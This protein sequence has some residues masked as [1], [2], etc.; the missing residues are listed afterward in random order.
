MGKVKITIGDWSEDGHNQY[1]EFVY[2][3][4]KSVKDIRQAYKDSC[5]LTGLQFNH[6]ENYTG[7]EVH[8]SYGTPYHICTEYDEDTISDIAMG[9]LMEHDIE[10]GSD[11]LSVDEFAELIIDFIKL[12]L[13]DLVL[14]EA[15]F[16]KSELRDISA[17]NGWWNHELNVGFGYGLYGKIN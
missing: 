8:N 4:N 17:V 3:S 15:S 14:E 5:K 9:I 16:K 13:P 11:Y 7:T 10:V 12:S 2:E 1:D 6:N